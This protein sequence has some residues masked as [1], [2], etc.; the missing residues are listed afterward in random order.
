MPPDTTKKALLFAFEEFIETLTSM[1]YNYSNANEIFFLSMRF[2][3]V[4]V[5]SFMKC[6]RETNF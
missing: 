6:L 5:I 3:L 1:Q 2:F 4:E